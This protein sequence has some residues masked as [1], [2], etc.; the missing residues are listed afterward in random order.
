MM[1]CWKPAIVRAN[2]RELLLEGHSPRSAAIMAH[3]I[4]RAAWKLG[5]R[6]ATRRRTSTW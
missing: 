2:I 6:P 3:R 5:R 4:A 1:L